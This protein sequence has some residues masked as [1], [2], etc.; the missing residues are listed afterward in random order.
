MTNVGD[1]CMSEVSPDR[2]SGRELL[3]AYCG[4]RA[5]AGRTCTGTSEFVHVNW[6]SH[7]VNDNRERT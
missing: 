3:E 6:M 4:V 1:K 2:S 7:Q 5:R